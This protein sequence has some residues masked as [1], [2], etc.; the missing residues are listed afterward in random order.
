MLYRSSIGAIA[1]AA[2]LG[3]VAGAQAF[4]EAKYPDWT[5]QWFRV[6]PIGQYNPSTPR[7]AQGAPLTPEYQAIFEANLRDQAAGGQGD[8]PTYVC[9]PDGMP[10]AMNAIF[11]MEMIIL[12][13]TTYFLIEY[14]TQIRRI[15]T[16]GRDFPTNEEPSFAGYSI[17]KWVDED[18]DGRYDTLLVE[19]RNFKGPRAYDPSGIPLHKDNKSV[20]K[21]RFYA[22]KD[23]PSLLHDEIT[24]IDNALSSPWTITKTYRRER[25][26][27]FIEANC[28]EDNPHV[29]LGKENYMLGA[30]GLLM[31]AK[32]D[33]PPPDLRHFKQPQ[34]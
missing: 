34:K 8:D 13:N 18:G 24:T 32:K 28:A 23:N 7:N 17:G 3:M 22:D 9:I 30:D 20:V 11:P 29:R 19:T 10:R 25:N 31:P 5:G 33:Q 12:P 16:D 27:I 21:E 2:A 26:P 4:D 1:L 14:L 15:F 6:G